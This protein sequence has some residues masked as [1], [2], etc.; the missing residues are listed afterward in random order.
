MWVHGASPD[1]NG[2]SRTFAVQD[3]LGLSVKGVQVLDKVDE[4]GNVGNGLFN[5]K[6][7]QTL[8]GRVTEAKNNDFSSQPL[9]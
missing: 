5:R 4:I 9:E 1:S 8:Q 6:V 3:D 7:T 2:S